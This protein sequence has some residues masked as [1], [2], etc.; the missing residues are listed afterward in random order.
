MLFKNVGMHVMQGNEKT[1]AIKMPVKQ[2][3][4]ETLEPFELDCDISESRLW[5]NFCAFYQLDQPGDGIDLIALDVRHYVG[6]V[7]VLGYE[8][9]LHY[10][11]PQ[12]VADHC[13]LIHG[14]FDHSLLW[15]HYIHY[16]LQRG[17]GVFMLD[18][19]GH[20]LSTGDEVAID[21]FSEYQ[22][23]LRAV[24]RTIEGVGVDRCIA[25]GQS[26]GG[27]ILSDYLLNCRLHGVSS[28]IKKGI[29][30]APL[31]RPSTWLKAQLA[32][33]VLSPVVD[34]VP[35][36]LTVNSTD[37]DFSYFLSELDPMQ[38]KRLSAKWVGALKKWIPYFKQLPQSD[39]NMLM[40]QGEKDTTVDY[41]YNLQILQKKFPNSTV[42]MLPDAYHHLMGESMEQ[43]YLMRAAIEQ[44]L[45]VE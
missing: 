2:Q 6:K 28:I 8:I 15:R 31:V 23:V 39:V 40:I 37:A 13:L 41:P 21:S 26:T 43:Q 19:P 33:S 4:I 3:L 10:L 1:I 22:H 25:M 27:A 45:T 16:W 17:R 14:L 30:L 5:N 34:Y 42:V 12:N 20:G 38:S 35:R 18:L 32:H 36:E 7:S 29:L 11:L 24:I 9:A 44:F